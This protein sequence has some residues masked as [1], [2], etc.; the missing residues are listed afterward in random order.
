MPDFL[1]PGTP[2]GH[3]NNLR[4]MRIFWLYKPLRYASVCRRQSAGE[5]QGVSFKHQTDTRH[6]TAGLWRWDWW[7]GSSRT[8]E[9]SFWR[10]PS[11][12]GTTGQLYTSSPADKAVKQTTIS[13]P[14]NN[15]TYSNEK[16]AFCYIMIY[17]FRYMALLEDTINLPLCGLFLLSLSALCIDAFSAVTVQYALHYACHSITTRQYGS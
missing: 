13:Q 6:I 10:I 8:E 12:A 15:I 14:T 9:H 5:V 16:R 3:G 1:N 2:T 7:T 17:Y 4:S 11:H